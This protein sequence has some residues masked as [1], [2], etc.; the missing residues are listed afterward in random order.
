MLGSDKAE[1]EGYIYEG[2][3]QELNEDEYEGTFGGNKSALKLGDGGKHFIRLHF[4]EFCDINIYLNKTVKTKEIFS[5][6]QL[7]NKEGK[8]K[9]K[10]IFVYFSKKEI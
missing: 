8:I 2:L 4:Y 5:M 7:Y 1:W 3:E 10:H 9:N 6:L